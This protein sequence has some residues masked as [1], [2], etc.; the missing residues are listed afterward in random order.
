ME[1]TA[2]F[3]LKWYQYRLR[4]LLLLMLATCLVMSCV[5]TALQKER[6]KRES[7]RTEYEGGGFVSDDAEEAHLKCLV[8]CNHYGGLYHAVIVR[9]VD[10]DPDLPDSFPSYTFHYDMDLGGDLRLDGK[11][12]EPAHRHHLLALGPF[13]RWEDLSLSPSEEA[14]VVKAN[15][16]RTWNNVVLKRLYRVEGGRQQGVRVG[17]WTYCDTKGRKD[18]EG[19]YVEGKRDGKW[20][21]YYEKGGVRAEMMYK[22]GHLD[23]DY[24]YYAP[25]G[26]LKDTVRWRE[27]YPV[28]RT[29]RQ[30]GF[31]YGE[32]RSP[33]GSEGYGN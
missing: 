1:E 4:S 24:K 33:H 17:H 9:N 27:G 32:V 16:S 22:L 12:I 18:F 28:D 21:Y 26:K 19:M 2:P 10:F 29:V 20:T 6:K 5:A 11:E 7:A 15:A 23:G 31:G 13:G 14:I 3:K 30:V 25:D 8:W